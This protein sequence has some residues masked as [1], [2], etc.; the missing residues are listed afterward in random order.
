MERPAVVEIGCV[1]GV[2]GGAQCVGETADG[3]GEAESVM[4]DDDLSHASFITTLLAGRGQ[5]G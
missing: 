2:A 1:N 5:T 4:E 3:I